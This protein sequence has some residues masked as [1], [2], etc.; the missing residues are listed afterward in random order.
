M[1]AIRS[2]YVLSNQLPVGELLPSERELALQMGV[3]RPVVHDGLMDLASKGLV[4]IKPRVGTYVNDYRKEGSIAMLS[5]LIN[6]QP[7]IV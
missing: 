6:H 4:T 5:T 7:H 2:Y 3:S 1:Y